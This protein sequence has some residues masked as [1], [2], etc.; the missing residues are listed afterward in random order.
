M[1]TVPK[2]LCVAPCA[3]AIFCS[4][5]AYGQPAPEP[6]RALARA[7][8]VSLTNVLA[9]LSPEEKARL[10]ADCRPTIGYYEQVLGTTNWSEFIAATSPVPPVPHKTF[11]FYFG[12]VDNFDD[13]DPWERLAFVYTLPVAEAELAPGDRKKLAVKD[14]QLRMMWIKT[15]LELGLENVL[16]QFKDLSLSVIVG[17]AHQRLMELFE[18]DHL[19]EVLTVEDWEI[20]MQ[21]IEALQKLHKADFQKI[22]M[23]R[24]VI[25]GRDIET[26]WFL[27]AGRFITNFDCIP[28][29]AAAI[30]ARDRGGRPL[31]TNLASVLLEPVGLWL[32][33]QCMKLEQLWAG[34]TN[35]YWQRLPYKPPSG[36]Q[37]TRGYLRFVDGKHLSPF[38]RGFDV[39][40]PALANICKTVTPIDVPRQ[41]RAI[42]EDEQRMLYIVQA[43][44]PFDPDAPDLA[45]AL[46]A[47]SRGDL[48]V[49]ARTLVIEFAMRNMAPPL[50]LLGTWAERLQKT[51]KSPSHLQIS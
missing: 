2:L 51:M 3:V 6:A 30:L 22:T 42:R 21:Y 8:I 36:L 25:T 27:F 13:L 48:D 7:A 14:K 5:I 35:I 50:D 10:L 18:Q 44:Q 34:I 37:S 28:K 33:H 9:R 19:F 32:E 1:K 4:T 11:Q 41:P 29:I 38:M 40:T 39:L 17:E 49:C 43:Y 31:N 12:V 46:E 20:V 23:Q 16:I 45:K 47:V 26:N 15:L 24:A